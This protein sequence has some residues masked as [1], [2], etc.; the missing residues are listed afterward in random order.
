MSN[1]LSSSDDVYGRQASCG[2]G[3]Q[4]GVAK[5]QLIFII[6]CALAVTVAAVTLISSF[7]GPKARHSTWQCP[8]CG[9]GFSVEGVPIPPVTCSKCG[10]KALRPGYRDCPACGK[11]VL[12]CQMRVEPP[13]EGATG[14]VG[15]SP[16]LGMGLPPVSVRF[17]IKQEDGSFAWSPWV[18][19]SSPQAQQIKLNMVCRECGESLFAPGGAGRGR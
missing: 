18:L 13:P 14:P 19:S 12:Y 9:H 6:I 7:S 5:D 16:G 2:I 8:D 17:W 4:P 10:G 1:R 3:A 11:K 15:G